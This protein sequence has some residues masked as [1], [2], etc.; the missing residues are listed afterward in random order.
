MIMIA[1]YD[2]ECTE[3]SAALLPFFTAS[4]L[5]WKALNCS[6]VTFDDVTYDEYVSPCELSK[7]TSSLSINDLFFLHCNV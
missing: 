6:K 3:C 2:C 4:N 5:E 7:L 1:Q